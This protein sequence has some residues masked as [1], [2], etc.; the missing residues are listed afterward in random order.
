MSGA[1]YRNNSE[2]IGLGLEKGATPFLTLASPA[3]K[4]V[5]TYS[6][7]S[8]VLCFLVTFREP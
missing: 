1:P 2:F 8:L 7:A 3:L 5:H 4:L 6:V